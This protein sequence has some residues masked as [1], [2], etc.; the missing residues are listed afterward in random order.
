MVL[1]NQRGS[2]MIE[3]VVALLI[4]SIL[5]VMVCTAFLSGSDLTANAGLAYNSRGAVYNDLELGLDSNSSSLIKEQSGS[6]TF[7]S[8]Y[9]GTIN[10]TY[11][12]GEGDY[13]V[14]EFV[15]D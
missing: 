4:F 9:V 14:G 1:F 2:T 7:S 11:R 3:H 6:I 13:Q 15:A 8:R 12:Y 5:A 10:G